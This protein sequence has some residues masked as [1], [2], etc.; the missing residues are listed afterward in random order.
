MNINRL[1]L[2]QLRMQNS[3]NTKLRFFNSNNGSSNYLNFSLK[4]NPYKLK[5]KKNHKYFTAK[6]KKI[7]KIR[8]ARVKSSF[9]ISALNENQSW[10]FWEEKFF[11]FF[12]SFFICVM[13]IEFSSLRPVKRII[14][15]C[16]TEHWC[17]WNFESDL[18]NTGEKNFFFFS[19][20]KKKKSKENVRNRFRRS[21]MRN[22]KRSI[23]RHVWNIELETQGWGGEEEK[24][25]SASYICLMQKQKSN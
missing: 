11:F 15:F 16:N 24:N 13:E 9:G 2:M 18:D 8:M 3:N 21:F 14:F 4:K 19:V 6:K 12:F 5:K 25:S 22:Q 7:Q 10:S 23:A 20:H 17:I 1:V